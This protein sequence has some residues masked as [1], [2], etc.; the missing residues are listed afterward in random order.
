M[1]D[2]IVDSYELGESLDELAE[3]LPALSA[4]QIKRLIEFAQ[5]QRGQQ[6]P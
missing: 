3:G 2:A 1:P 5:G 6:S 4:A